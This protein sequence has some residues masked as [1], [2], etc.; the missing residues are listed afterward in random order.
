MEPRMKASHFA[1]NKELLTKV[2]LNINKG[3]NK[4]KK[5]LDA[6]KT[7]PKSNLNPNFIAPRGIMF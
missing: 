1:K 2:K 5:H 6:S 3:N 7:N 4:V